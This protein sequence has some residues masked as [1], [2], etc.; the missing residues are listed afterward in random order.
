M[1]QRVYVAGQTNRAVEF[2]TWTVN[3]RR[4]LPTAQGSVN[5]AL[6]TEI[7]KLLAV[8]KQA[9][10]CGSLKLLFLL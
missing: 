1:K 9:F 8:P 7:T 4:R 5:I 3:Q 2:V 10:C 6:T